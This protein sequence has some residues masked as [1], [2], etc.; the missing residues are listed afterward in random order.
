HAWDTAGIKTGAEGDPLKRSGKSSG[1]LAPLGQLGVV[2]PQ[3]RT[4]RDT[5]LLNLVPRGMSAVAA[6]FATDRALWERDDALKAAYGERPLTG[7]ADLY[8]V[9]A[10]RVRLVPSAGESGET[11]VR[12]VVLAAGDRIT[13]G[14]PFRFEPHTVF[15]RDLDAEKKTKRVPEYV[16]RRHVPGRALWRGMPGLLAQGSA[17]GVPPAG[18]QPAMLR[19]PGA[20]RWIEDLV[21]HQ[22]VPADL[23]LRVT[24]YGAHYGQKSA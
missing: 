17:T 21:N 2:V 8:T 5:L 7:P 10:R 13:P 1:K 4:L 3:G 14:E 11:V 19:G 18:R 20:L 16:P 24:S 15:R 12:H 23:V 22:R 6:H 9:P